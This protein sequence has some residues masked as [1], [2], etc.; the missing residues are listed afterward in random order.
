MRALFFLLLLANAVFFAWSQGHFGGVDE[1][2]EPQRMDQQ[3]QADKLRIVREA[4]QPAPKKE[5]TACRIIDGLAP[6]AAEALKAAAASGGGEA[7]LLPLPAT[8]RHLVLI[9]DLAN[10]AAAEKK[11]AELARL[12][13]EAPRLAALEGGRHEIVLG[14]FD[15]EPAAR[16]FLQGLGKRG[17]KTARIEAREQPAEKARVEMRGP[18]A[19]LLQE[20]P[21]LIAPHADAKLGDCPP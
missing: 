3:L 12:G 20:L 7:R 10:K 16:E 21:K 8:T 19:K 9:G 14:G 2:R 18:A 1:N 15:T 17:I 11:L 6:A 5:E 4:A 13:A